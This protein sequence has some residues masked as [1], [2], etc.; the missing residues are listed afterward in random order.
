MRAEDDRII[1]SV[2][3]MRR[4]YDK[5]EALGDAVTLRRKGTAGGAAWRMC[6][7]ATNQSLIESERCSRQQGRQQSSRG[8]WQARPEDRGRSP[9]GTSW[10]WRGL[11]WSPHVSSSA[12]ELS[13]HRWRTTSSAVKVS[14]PPSKVFE[15]EHPIPGTLLLNPFSNGP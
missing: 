13:L 8:G 4:R 9:S 1:E 12:M 5:G 7:L 15:P 10:K 6:C 3:A 14:M 2:V 11:A